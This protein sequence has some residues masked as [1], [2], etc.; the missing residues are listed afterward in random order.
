MIHL[1]TSFIVDLLR[2]ARKGLVGPARAKLEELVD[3][4]LRVSLH[5]MCELYAGVELSQ[6]PDRERQAVATLVAGWQIV[7]PKESLA[8]VY[9]RVLADLQSQ[10]QKIATM[11]LLI[12]A[13]ALVDD[14]PLL[15]ANSKHF[16]RV[17]RLTVL[18]Y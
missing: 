5:V 3:T 1:D 8:P 17:P 11:D 4:E 9:G 13:T 12:A 6:W 2:E 7:E 18:D 16:S 10:G 15:T 14:A